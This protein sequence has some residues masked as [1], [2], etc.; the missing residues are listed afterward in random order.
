M[1]IYLASSWRNGRYE[2]VLRCLRLAGHEVYDFKNPRPGDHGFHWSEIDPDWESWPARSLREALNHPLARKG[3]ASDMAALK[4]AQAVVLVMPCGRS[5]HL[6]LGYAVGA[7]KYTAILLNDRQEPEL[8]Y[9]MA[10]RL[11]LSTTELVHT[12]DLFAHHARWLE[13][14][15]FANGPDD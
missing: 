10:D 11:C 5:A 6:E 4:A 14:A 9:A 7:R 2:E 15:R 12:V 3:F 8:M 1:K 13:N